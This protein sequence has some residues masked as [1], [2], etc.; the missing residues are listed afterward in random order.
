MHAQS[1][2]PKMPERIKKEKKNER[3]QRD[4]DGSQ[5][6]VM[7]YTIYLT[8]A[9]QCR[10]LLPSLISMQLLFFAETGYPFIYAFARQSL[11]CFNK[12][13]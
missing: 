6:K 3:N 2:L 5:R 8:T 9:T 4:N 1:K 10:L 13:D 12:I 11:T 7:V